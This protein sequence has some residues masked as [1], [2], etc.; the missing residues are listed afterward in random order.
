M[1]MVCPGGMPAEVGRDL[2]QQRLTPL[3]TVD[4][5][6]G[7]QHPR[8]P[9]Q[10]RLAD[11]L[12]VLD[13][14]SIHWTETQEQTEGPLEDSPGTLTRPNCSTLPI[15]LSDKNPNTNDSSTIVS[16]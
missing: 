8:T 10:Q 9:S 16:D 3:L 5:P 13:P 7:C 4:T 2:G 15:A 6:R 11:G 1:L 12:D 14:L